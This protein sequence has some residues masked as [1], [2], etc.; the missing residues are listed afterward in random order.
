ML[1]GAPILKT[2]KLSKLDRF[3]LKEEYTQIGNLCK[4]SKEKAAAPQMF[5]RYTV[6]QGTQQTPCYKCGKTLCSY[7]RGPK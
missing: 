4:I 6:I 3:F 1:R 7:T 5:I 2:M